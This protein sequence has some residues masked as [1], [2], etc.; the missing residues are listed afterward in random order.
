MTSGETLRLEEVSK[1]FG[2]IQ[3]LSDI[4]FTL[5]G[6][7][8]AA[9]VGDNA[10]GKSTLLKAVAG[11]YKPDKGKMFLEGREVEFKS[12]MDARK[13]GIE[14]VFQD[15]MLCPDLDVTS[16]VFL[17][18]EKTALQVLR[19]KEMEKVV[20]SKLEEIK[21]DIPFLRRKV[22]FLS[23]GQQQMASILR[24]LMFE[25]RI[26]LLDEPTASLSAAASAEVM[27]FIRRLKEKISI[28]YVTHDLPSV[29]KYSDRITVL[30]AGRIVAERKPRE[31]DPEVLTHELIKLM[32]L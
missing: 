23:G 12:P 8:I 10:A 25:P 4:D 28:I 21:F 19:K 11:I 26:L 14:M 3:A 32:R 9:L 18:R 13:N 31:A 15:F 30:R 17:G 27:E 20:R 29:I 16:N 2:A 22:K 6:H 24:T 1:S 5:Y 7:E